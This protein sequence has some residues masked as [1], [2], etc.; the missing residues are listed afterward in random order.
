[1]LRLRAVISVVQPLLV[2]C[3]CLCVCMHSGCVFVRLCGC[4][5]NLATRREVVLSWCR[6]HS[7]K[8]Q[9]RGCARVCGGGPLRRFATH[10]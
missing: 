1:M 5:G 10:R 4:V 2:V 3:A 9:V 7:V 6:V 8:C